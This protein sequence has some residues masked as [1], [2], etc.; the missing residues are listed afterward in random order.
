MTIIR[1]TLVAMLLV[2]MFLGLVIGLIIRIKQ[3]GMLDIEDVQDYLEEMH[4][5]CGEKNDET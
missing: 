3:S 2:G 5:K 1:I 4:N